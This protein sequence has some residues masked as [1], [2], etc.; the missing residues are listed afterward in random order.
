MQ[1]AKI[2]LA[3]KLKSF[4]AQNAPQDDKLLN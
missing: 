1:G 2:E 4:V 3:L